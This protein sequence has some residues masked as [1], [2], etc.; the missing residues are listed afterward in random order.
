MACKSLQSCRKQRPILFTKKQ[1][2]QD[3][4]Y[5]MPRQ[6]NFALV[7]GSYQVCNCPGRMHCV[8]A[9]VSLGSL[10]WYRARPFG[11]LGS[12]ADRNSTFPL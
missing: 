2:K 11:N 12:D 3:L 5:A 9:T 4:Q 7:P 10:Q 1:S 8:R 6:A